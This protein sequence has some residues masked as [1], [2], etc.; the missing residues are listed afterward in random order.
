M[1]N[2]DAVK[3]KQGKIGANKLNND[4]RVSAIIV[5]TPAIPDLP[6]KETVTLFGL[7]DAAQYGITEA[8]DKDNNVNVYRH[9]REFYRKAGE[10]VQLNF[11][12]VEQTETVKTIAED[13]D[14][15]KLKRFIAASLINTTAPAPSDICELLPAVTDPLAANTG[16]NFAKAS[17]LVSARGPSSVP[18]TTF[19]SCTVCVAKS[20]CFSS[21]V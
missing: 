15:D 11:M 10:G 14:G 18:L 12:A 9:V 1:A 20:G 8:F 6:F 3:I 21:T 19:S 7:F 13:V 16:F 5:G 4:R 2:L 17:R